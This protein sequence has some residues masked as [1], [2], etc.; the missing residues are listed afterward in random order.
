MWA[1]SD[2]DPYW[3]SVTLELG[4]TQFHGTPIAMASVPYAADSDIV[5]GGDFRQSLI[6]AD[7]L[8][9]CGWGCDRAAAALSADDQ[10]NIRALAFYAIP[11]STQPLLYAGGQDLSYG[12]N[13]LARWDG[14]SWVVLPFW[15]ND[16]SDSITG[17]KVHNGLALD[18][19][20]LRDLPF[21]RE[22]ISA[23]PS[24]FRDPIIRM[25]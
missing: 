21:Q 23:T 6:N 11:P 12:G 18:H 7:L 15:L 9:S 24:V 16:N 1:A 3:S 22:R 17:L 10:S 4:R 19:H 2:T 8:L 14:F 25:V 20:R 5:L 13:R